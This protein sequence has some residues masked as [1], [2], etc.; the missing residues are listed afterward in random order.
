MSRNKPNR[1]T[2]RPDCVTAWSETNL[3]EIKNGGFLKP[4]FYTIMYENV[5]KMD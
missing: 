3:G 1:A 4:F 5:R 2:M